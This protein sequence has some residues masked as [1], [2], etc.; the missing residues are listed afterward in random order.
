MYKTFLM[1]V[2]IIRVLY[3]SFVCVCLINERPTLKK[4]MFLK[5]SNFYRLCFI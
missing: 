1:H 2:I 5:K 4:T 3:H